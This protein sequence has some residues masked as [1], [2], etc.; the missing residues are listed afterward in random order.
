[1]LHAR[2]HAVRCASGVNC[3]QRHHSTA[4]PLHTNT[5][6]HLFACC[7]WQVPVLDHVLDLP[8]HC[9]G[10]QQQPIQQQDGPEHWHIKHGEEGHGHANPKRLDG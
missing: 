2:M 1:M 6:T 9:Y 8:L 5:V 10:E 3:S 4:A 7:E